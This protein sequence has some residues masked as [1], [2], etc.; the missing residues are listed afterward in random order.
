MNEGFYVVGLI[1]VIPMRRQVI[2]RLGKRKRG[3]DKGFCLFP[4]DEGS[5]YYDYI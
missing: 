5:G 2:N 1:K 4:T 3:D